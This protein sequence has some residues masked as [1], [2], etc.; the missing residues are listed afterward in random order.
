[1]NNT[2]QLFEDVAEISCKL[3]KVSTNKRHCEQYREQCA[4]K[5]L[6]IASELSKKGWFKKDELVSLIEES[7]KTISKMRGVLK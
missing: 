7:E 2:K 4:K 3:C 6:F 5:S 1:M